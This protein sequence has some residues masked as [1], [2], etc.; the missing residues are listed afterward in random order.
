MESV[1]TDR[2]ILGDVV[3]RGTGGYLSHLTLHFS[4]E[5]LTPWEGGKPVLPA[6]N[7]HLSITVV[8]GKPR[9]YRTRR[10][11]FFIG[12]LWDRL[13]KVGLVNSYQSSYWQLRLVVFAPQK[14]RKFGGSDGRMDADACVV[15][16]RDAL[17]QVGFVDDDMRI[18]AGPSEVIYR[19]SEPGLIIDLKRVNDRGQWRSQWFGDLILDNRGE[20]I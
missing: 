1:A 20:A 9:P 4:S 17:Q 10:A 2:Q 14:C 11:K 6:K 16:V 5:D 15:P 3:E 8:H 19:K 7:D 12:K 13:H 18:L